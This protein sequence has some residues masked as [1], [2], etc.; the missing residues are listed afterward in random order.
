[1]LE[2]EDHSTQASDPIVAQR[3]FKP[4]TAFDTITQKTVRRI[5]EGVA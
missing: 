1:M 3:D 4:V 2:R 5:S